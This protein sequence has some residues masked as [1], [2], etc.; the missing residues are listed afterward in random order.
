MG[1]E[2]RRKGQQAPAAVI[3]YLHLLTSTKGVDLQELIKQAVKGL[4][5]YAKEYN[6]FV[7]AITASNRESNKKGRL[8]MESGRD[9]SSIEYTGDYVISLNYYEIDKYASN[10]NAP[11]AVN[12]NN[13]DA[14]A[15]L[16]EQPRRI[17]ILRV[18][19]NRFGSPGRHQNVIFDTVNNIFYGTCDEFFTD[20]YEDYTDEPQT[21]ERI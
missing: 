13:V 3:D 10:K 21:P 11:G 6:T 14:V 16:Q 7:I 8:T 20:S 17:M 18:L 19:K 5:D 1:A 2:A 15:R 9:S 4:K 12:P